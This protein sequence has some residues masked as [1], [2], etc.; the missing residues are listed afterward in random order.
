MSSTVAKSP[1]TTPD[2]SYVS[3]CRGARACL[4]TVLEKNGQ[5]P[6]KAVAQDVLGRDDEPQ[7]S[8]MVGGTRPFDLDALDRVPRE[9]LVAWVK[10]YGR[11]LGLVVREMDLPEL[12][13]RVLLLVDELALVSRLVRVRRPG[14][15]L[16]APLPARDVS[17]VGT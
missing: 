11:E 16:R 1:M 4:Q 10:E 14:I 3:A 9:L 12:T 15:P 5:L 2:N 13:E 6:R 8:K 7:F 17:K